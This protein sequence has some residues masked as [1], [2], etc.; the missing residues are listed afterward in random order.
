METVG[1]ARIG[2]AYS[3]ANGLVDLLRNFWSLGIDVYGPMLLGGLVMGIPIGLLTYRISLKL[4]KETKTE[5]S[6]EKQ[7][8]TSEIEKEKIQN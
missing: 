1:F 7:A 5:E 3:S 6:I 2:E 8:E 4:F